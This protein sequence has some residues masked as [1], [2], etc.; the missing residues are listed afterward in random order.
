MNIPVI[1]IH[2]PQQSAALQASTGMRLTITRRGAVLVPAQDFK[3][4]LDPYEQT[5]RE[6]WLSTPGAFEGDA[7]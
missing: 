2:T 1:G 7:A 6:S 4:L 3:G 5:D